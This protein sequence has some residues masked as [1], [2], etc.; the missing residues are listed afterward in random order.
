VARGFSGWLRH[1]AEHYLLVDAQRKLSIKLG[2]AAP[3][4]PQ[5]AKEIFWLKV[6]AP[7]YS[8]LPWSLRHTVM[9]AMPGSHRKTWASPPALQGP[10]V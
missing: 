10:A 2:T 8:V 7:V 6:F 3:R 5:G 1:N 9:R 4:P